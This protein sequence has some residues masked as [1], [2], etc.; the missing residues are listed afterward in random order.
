MGNRVL[1]VEDEP[2]LL[3]VLEATLEYGGFESVV[4]RT[5]RAAVELFD[6]GGIDAVLLD[7]GLPD[8]DG[9]ELL[10]QLRERSNLPIIVVSGHDTESDRIAALDLGADDF[11]PKPFL[12]GELLARI[13]AALRRYETPAAAAETA[14]ADSDTLNIDPVQPLV[15]VSGEIIYL[16]THEHKL[17]TTLAARMDRAVTVDEIVTEIWGSADPLHQGNL[18]VL[19]HKLREK[20]EANPKAPR[21]LLTVHGI[22]YRLRAHSKENASAAA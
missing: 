16:T 11:V 7:L 19:I 1:I 17:L 15:T 3:H 14:G 5:G 6:S 18:R 13:R 9:S 8:L 4:A 10:K 12:P 22:G 2:T 21:F 20:I